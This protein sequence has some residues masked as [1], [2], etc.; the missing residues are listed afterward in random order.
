MLKRGI[1]FLL[2]GVMCMG[3]AFGQQITRMAVVD[4]SRIYTTFFRESQAVREFEERSTR[5]Q[6][7]LA[8]I[9]REIQDL[10]TR[11]ADAVQAGNQTEA[12]R[13][14]TQ[15]NQRSEFL[16]ELHQ[17]R[18]NELNT[19]RSNLLQSDSFMRQVHEGIRFAAESEGYSAVFDFRNTPGLVWNSPSVDITDNV[20]QRLQRTRN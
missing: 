10:R 7:E 18:T 15:I 5:V 3:M 14:E 1:I 19:A 9:Q 17:T 12:L 13:L 11:R 2:L 4:L 6:A 8:A 20:I 16:R